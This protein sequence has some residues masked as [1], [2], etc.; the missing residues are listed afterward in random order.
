MA[1]TVEFYEEEDGSA[2]VE[3][4]LAHL[5]LEHRAKALA[6]VKLLEEKGPSLPF[7]TLRRFGE[8]FGS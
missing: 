3:D 2:P 1:W 7:L 4:F 8:S 5:P 6:I